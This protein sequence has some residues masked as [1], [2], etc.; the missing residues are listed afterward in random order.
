VASEIWSAPAAPIQH[1]AAL[2]FTEP[3]AITAR[4]AAS[5]ALHARVAAAVAAACARAGLIVPP[6]QAGFYVYPD[7]GPW[8]GHLHD[9]YQITTSAALA[10]LL[11]ARYGVATLP[12]S[13]FGEP[14]TALRLRL[15][16]AQLY[17]D[18][19]QQQET[20]LA[21]PDPTT[22]PWITAALTQLSHT[23]T[24]LTK[25]HPRPPR[26]PAVRSAQLTQGADNVLW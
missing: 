24:D 26:P 2:A 1:A 8:R 20:A 5:R 17:G 18:T 14:P 11:L 15:A 9:R 23:L 12:G 22:L 7:F 10:R 4:I 21:A 16:T 3:P 13:V 6:P 25:L 19:P